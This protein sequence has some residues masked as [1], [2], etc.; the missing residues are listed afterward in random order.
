MKEKT[1]INE[2]K[3]SPKEIET[4]MSCNPDVRYQYTI[5]RIADTETLWTLGVDNQT[6]AIQKS[7]EDYLLPIWSSKEFAIIFGSTFMKEYNCFPI[8]LDNFEESI[9]DI[10]CENGYLLNVFPTQTE[11]IGKVVGINSFSEDLS[12]ALSEYN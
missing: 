8:S 2:L 4:L 3:I 12:A 1:P 9:I 10:I 5:K 6:F 11:E 7:G